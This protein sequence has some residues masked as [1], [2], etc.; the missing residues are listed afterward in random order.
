MTY[1]YGSHNLLDL[2]NTFTRCRPIQILVIM[3]CCSDLA[4]GVEASPSVSSPV[5]WRH[6]TFRANMKLEQSINRLTQGSGYVMVE[7]S[8]NTAYIAEFD[9]I[10][11]EMKWILV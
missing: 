6:R 9:Q 4:T 5:K 1:L 10:F 2:I 11:H 8:G 3:L 7:K